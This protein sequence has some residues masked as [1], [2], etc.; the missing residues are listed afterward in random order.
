MEGIY[1]KLVDKY[2]KLKSTK[3]AEIA[4][5]NH[6]QEVKFMEYKSA[7]D[8]LIE[9][10]RNENF[11]L[12]SQIIDLRREMTSIRSSSANHRGEPK[13]NRTEATD[14]SQDV[15]NEGIH[16]TAGKDNTENNQ[17]VISNAIDNLNSSSNRKRRTRVEP[18]AVDISSSNSTRKRRK[19]H[20][21]DEEAT[22]TPSTDDHA[23]VG[24]S[25]SDELRQWAPFGACSDIN[26]PACCRRIK[27]LSGNC[28]NSGSVVNCVFQ[29]LI[30]HLLGMKLSA[31]IQA[32]GISIS[33]CHQSS[34]YAFKLTVEEASGREAELV[35]KPIS[36][37]TIEMGAPEW[38][39]EVIIFSMFMSPVFFERVLR[40]I[41]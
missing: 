35:Y 27:D 7:A 41:K 21:T 40:V 8:E 26:Q 17:L 38:M 19:H 30:E 2:N 9:H 4:S 6:D 31:A 10:L 32:D 16:Q 14:K 24:E 36:L 20:G 28:V 37:G 15:Q 34:G 22:I 39:K 33:A 18:E 13:E 29:E 5:I 1:S 23:P 11:S 3:D 25:T 12:H